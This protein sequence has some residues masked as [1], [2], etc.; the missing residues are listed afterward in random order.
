VYNI[1][2][3]KDLRVI[4]NRELETMIIIDNCMGS[5]GQA[6]GNGV[7]I[8]AFEGDPNDRELPL[9]KDY[10]VGLSLLS[11]EKF[12]ETNRSTFLLEKIR[13]CKEPVQYLSMLPSQQSIS[14][15]ELSV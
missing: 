3:I 6:L 15:K 2:A 1:S 11:T 5:F 10:L 14:L 7:P 8:L 12:V 4:Q 9:L 13:F